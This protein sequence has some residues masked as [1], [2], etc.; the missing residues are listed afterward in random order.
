M[1]RSADSA[2][3]LSKVSPVGFVDVPTAAAFCSVS[4][5]YLDQLRIIGGGPKFCRRGRKI[6]YHVPDL[7]AWGT[8]ERFAS[9]AQAAAGL[10]AA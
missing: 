5:S 7:I 3:D 2:I 6:V 8:K 1:A 9:N 4:K 10:E